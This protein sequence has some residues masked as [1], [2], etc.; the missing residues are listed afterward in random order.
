MRW[1][2]LVWFVSVTAQAQTPTPMKHA[3]LSLRNDQ[4]EI[5]YTEAGAGDVTLL[6]VHG[7]CINR[8]Y[9]TETMAAFADEHQVMAIDLPG[10]GESTAKRTQYT[11]AE[12]AEDILA[13]ADEK[14]L[15]KVVLVAHSMAGDIMLEIAQ[16]GNPNIIGL[17]GVDNFK[18]V[19]VALSPEQL[20]QFQTLFGAMAQDFATGAP[21]Y[22][23]QLLFLP[24]SP[25]DVRQR[26]MDDFAKANPAVAM[27]ASQDF[28]QYGAR[29]P[30][31]LS[32]LELPLGLVN[33]DGVPNNLQALETYCQAGVKLYP[34]HGTGHYPM[35]ENPAQF[36]EGLR[37]IVAW[38]LK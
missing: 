25:K 27:S 13:F 6:F 9:W 35:V 37:E 10:F 24:E 7:W 14:A 17:I 31:L 4:V 5:H 11:M 8:N 2:P 28:A 22:A 23:D 21:A 34:I 36:Q 12:Y 20:A 32:Q 3:S 26:V 18:F 19:D 33:S 1:L 30:Q 29:Y 38:V 15:E 16:R